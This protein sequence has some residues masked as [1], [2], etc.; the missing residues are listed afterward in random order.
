MAGL[1]TGEV[2]SGPGGEAVDEAG[3]A[4][5]PFEP[6]LPQRGQL[7]G[8]LLG[9]V[10]QSPLQVRPT[11]SGQGLLPPPGDGRFVALGCP[12]R[13]APAD[14]APTVLPELFDRNGG[15]EDFP[16]EGGHR[17]P[18]VGPDGVD[19]AIHGSDALVV[20]VLVAEVGAAACFV[21]GSGGDLDVLAE[22]RA[23]AGRPGV[24]D[25]PAQVRR[26]IAGVVPRQVHRAVGGINGEP[27]VELVVGN[28][29]LV[30]VHPQ[31][32][33]IEAETNRRA[34]LPYATLSAAERSRLVSGLTELPG[35]P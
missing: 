4:P 22:G 6:G 9:E 8:A 26:V 23:A 32:E 7:A 20:A 28:P 1:P 34:G 30:V 27:L 19:R 10:G 3:P 31:R 25:V 29:G 13:Y 24:E 5:H 12:D 15:C 14:P 16:V 18:P 35:K 11:P 17:G 2:E 21:G 33:R